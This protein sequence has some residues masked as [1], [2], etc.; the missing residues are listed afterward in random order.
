MYVGDFSRFLLVRRRRR[1]RER[2]QHLERGRTHTHRTD[3]LQGNP[4]IALTFVPVGG[5][6]ETEEVSWV[7]Y[8][9]RQR[10]Q[11]YELNSAAISV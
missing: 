5:P 1:A 6:G 10:R 9:S 2:G 11:V 7:A 8:A 4:T 3:V